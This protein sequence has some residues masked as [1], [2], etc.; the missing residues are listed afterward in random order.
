MSLE[1]KEQ[2]NTTTGEESEDGT[3]ANNILK[4]AAVDSASQIVALFAP[5]SYAA[6]IHTVGQ[7]ASTYV[8]CQ[9]TIGAVISVL[10]TMVN[11]VITNVAVTSIVAATSSPTPTA[12]TSL[13]KTASVA[14][15]KGVLTFA[16]NGILEK[17][18]SVMASKL[19]RKQKKAK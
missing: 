4:L 19:W 17:V 11:A 6:P 2:K 3:T 18:A 9:S 15:Y 5:S 8:R 12:G 7:L 10:Q 1:S 13:W 14:V 16:V